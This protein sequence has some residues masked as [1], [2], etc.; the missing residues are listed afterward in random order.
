MAPQSVREAYDTLKRRWQA[1]ELRG[2][3][4][5]SLPSADVFRSLVVAH[6][7]MT[8]PLQHDSNTPLDNALWDEAIH[9]TDNFMA[10]WADGIWN[11]ADPTIR[12]HLHAHMLDYVSL[13]LQAPAVVIDHDLHTIRTAM[14][15]VLNRRQG[16]RCSLPDPVTSGEWMALHDPPER[17]A[18]RAI[19]LGRSASTT[20]T[21][22]ERRGPASGTE[23]TH[24]LAEWLAAMQLTRAE[25]SQQQLAQ[26]A[27]VA[28]HAAEVGD[29]NGSKATGANDC[30]A[31]VIQ[32]N[33]AEALKRANTNRYPEHI[34]ELE[35][36]Q[37]RPP[38][39]FGESDDD[40]EQGGDDDGEIYLTGSDN[41]SSDRSSPTMPGRYVCDVPT[42]IDRT[43]NQS[44]L[45]GEACS[46][47]KALR[48]HKLEAHGIED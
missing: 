25:G 10:K 44:I 20:A 8:P 42:G 35:L 17:T 18:V 39:E 28:E 36:N 45:C 14:Q 47:G 24:N 46:D 7:I 3:W 4:S 26:P 19:H 15:V 43:D 22:R 27:N 21:C 13:L 9:V 40:P 34:S 32:N 1:Y 38:P 29:N 33:Y 6:I 23:D 11:L 12:P 30:E 48:R 41:S 2:P 37:D 5:A 31:G 16:R